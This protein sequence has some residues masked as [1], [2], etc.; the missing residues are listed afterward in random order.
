[1]KKAVILFAAALLCLAGT[2]VQAQK[3]IGGDKN[4]EFQFSPLGGN[5]IGINGLRFRLFNSETSAIRVN[6]FLGSSTITDVINQEGE[7]SAESP[8]SPMLQSYD[9]AFDFTIRPGY[10]IHFE[11]TDRLSP[12]VGAE[13]DFG[14]GSTSMETEKWGADQLSD[15]VPGKFV[16]WS[17]TDKTSFT[18]FGINLLAGFDYYFADNLYLGAEL[19]FGF[20]STTFG[21]DTFEV[22]NT[23]AW[24]FENSFGTT[25]DD[26][27]PAAVVNGSEFNVG[28]TVNGR[29]RLGFLIN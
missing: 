10:E 16:V 4:L 29:I 26:D 19:G 12:Y 20:S 8:V 28:P 9:R 25:L 18:R 17:E 24:S 14:M 23:A 15:P 13:I 1:M 6:F 11:G 5:P 22:S 3:Q 2:Q 27:L 7:L 21:D